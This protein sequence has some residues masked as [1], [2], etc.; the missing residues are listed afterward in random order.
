MR[1]YVVT[2]VCKALSPDATHR[3]ISE[4]C[5]QGAIHFT[6]TEVIDSLSEGN[7]FRTLA[8]GQSAEVHVVESCPHD[9]CTLG[10]YLA[11]NPDSTGADNLENLPSC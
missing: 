4:L 6:R 5:T 3:H 10:P 8:R 11:T 7:A 2:G 1:E 9:G